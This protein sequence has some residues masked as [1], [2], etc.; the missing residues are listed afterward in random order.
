[1]TTTIYIEI[2]KLY[3][4]KTFVN[5][6]WLTHKV[7]IKTTWEM[8]SVCLILL[9]PLWNSIKGFSLWRTQTARGVDLSTCA[10]I[11]KKLTVLSI[12]F[13][14]NKQMSSSSSIQ[15]PSDKTH[16]IYHT[17]LFSHILSSYWLPK[18]VYVWYQLLWLLE[19]LVDEWK[20][21]SL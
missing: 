11:V 15:M 21:W 5:L 12:C 8:F 19:K 1:M 7:S 14:E 2:S 16:V 17:D 9:I 3:I 18:C 13:N 6:C 4:K 20:I 10:C